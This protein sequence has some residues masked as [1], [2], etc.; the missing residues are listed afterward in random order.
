MAENTLTMRFDRD[1][2]TKELADLVKRCYQENPDKKDLKE[3]RRE[4][5]ENP[6]LWENVFDLT[7]VVRDYLVSKVIENPAAQAGVESNIKALRLELGYEQS[8][9]VE[10][11]LIDNVV[12]CWLRVGW[13]EY[14]LAGLMGQS[15]LRF[16]E[17]EFW[18][19][20]LSLTQA[21]YLRA[22]ESLA[23]VRK[24]TR[25]TMQINIAEPGSQQV[26]IA[27]DLVRN[28]DNP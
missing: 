21:R 16:S 25:A 1:R 10:Q 13:V 17:I 14:H 18:E 24:L 23:R 2:M 22:L 8:P 4:L 11:L 28:N 26:N 12:N 7:R 19:K 20:R 27:G 6:E 3:L 5:A 9:M 15:G